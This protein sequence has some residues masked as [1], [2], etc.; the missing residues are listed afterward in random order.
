M[1]IQ[2]RPFAQATMLALGL[3]LAA[4]L[5]AQLP[6]A[7][8]NRT[9]GGV[10]VSDLFVREPATGTPT[11]L[12]GASNGT[13]GG[14]GISDLFVLDSA[15][16][17][18]TLVGSIGFEN[19]SGLACLGDGRMVASARGDDIVPSGGPAS[20]LIEIDPLTGAG[21]LIGTIVDRGAGGN[22]GRMSDLTGEYGILYGYSDNCNPGFEGLY[23]I[24]AYGSD[25]G[26]GTP[27]GPSGYNGYGNGLSLDFNSYT[28]Y[29][30]PSD[31]GSLVILDPNTGDGMD[32]PGSNFNVPFRV[33]ALAYDS[34]TDVLYGS[35]ANPVGPSNFLV[36]ID[37]SDGTTTV[38]GPTVLG[39]EAIVFECPM[40]YLPPVA[41]GIPTLG[42][43]GLGLLALLLAASAWAVLRRRR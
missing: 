6:H 2:P 38:L 35:W 29:A 7:A 22:C 26:T 33:N 23:E 41:A 19:V 18:P 17:T 5:S 12:Y 31:F 34:Y 4:P 1:V 24:E 15:S 25:T 14:V 13:A 37:T 32:V 28:L 40:I 20:V 3:L 43:A 9:P 8:S 21:S 42:G 30:T 36:T 16:G 39:L 27:I 10:A 11:R